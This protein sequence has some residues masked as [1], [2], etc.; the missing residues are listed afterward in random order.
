MK[1]L[2]ADPVKQSNA[3]DEAGSKRRQTGE[4]ENR[5]VEYFVRLYCCQ[6]VTSH[7]GS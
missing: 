2:F 6:Q 7:K 4:K 1:Q 3:D 5:D